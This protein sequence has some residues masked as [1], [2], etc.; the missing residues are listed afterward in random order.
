MHRTCLSMVALSLALCACGSHQ[1]SPPGDTA[2]TL[3]EANRAI[4]TEYARLRGRGATYEVTEKYDTAGRVEHNPDIADGLGGDKQFLESRREA[5]PD[6]YDPVNKYVNVVHLVLAD[7]DLVA[8]KSHLFASAKDPG[9]EFLD[10]W[11]LKDGKFVEHW[12]IIQPIASAAVAQG[13]LGCGGGLTYAAASK[14]K[15]TADNPTCGKPDP[16]A[17]SAANR[18]LVL[19]YMELGQQPGRLADAVN[20]YL[21][22]DFVQHSPNIPAGRQGLLDYLQARAKARA[23]DKRSQKI[24]HVI[25]DGDLVLV[26]RWVTSASDPRGSAYIDIFRVKGGKISEH[27]D[28]VQ[29]IPANSL[30]GHSMT[31]GVDT[32]LE[33]QRHK[34]PAESL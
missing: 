17:D 7:G 20:R 30:A 1:P 22:A 27:W 16:T 31:G 2:Q 18:K 5:H 25:A 34:G 28:I 3:T 12:D 6:K 15:D 10:M 29:P 21:A 26:H 13:M 4:I 14:L 32:P 24:Q 8:V 9:R 19:D 11:R 33:P 23:A